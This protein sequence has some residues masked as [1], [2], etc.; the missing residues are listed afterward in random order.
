MRY[1]RLLPLILMLIFSAC[2]SEAPSS[3]SSVKTPAP[4]VVSTPMGAPTVTPTM[5]I[6]PSREVHFMTSDHIQL[7][8]LLF[9]HGKVAVICS[10]E[11]RTTKAIWSSTDV[12]SLLATRGYMVLAYDFRGNGDSQGSS[13]VSNL[14]VD[15]QAAV[16]YMQKQGATKIILMGSSMGGTATLQV[17]SSKSVAAIVTLSAPLDFG[18]GV[19]DSNL[20][21]IQAPKLFVNSNDDQFAGDTQHSY[22]IVSQPKE[23]HMY[24][25]SAHGTSIFQ[26]PYGGDLT[27]LILSFIT[28]YVPA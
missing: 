3:T 8:G 5:A 13:D 27:R 24:P 17:A 14:N 15:L 1:G 21:N 28:H 7:A 9:G 20:K 4:T 2:N 19:S 26:G 25:G 6:A 22:A 11:L 12:V 18:S 16:A 23:L 10:H